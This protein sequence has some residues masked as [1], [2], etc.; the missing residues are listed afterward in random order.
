MGTHVDYG[1]SGPSREEKYTR[2]VTMGLRN[3]KLVR[4]IARRGFTPDDI[5]RQTLS[6]RLTEGG[7]QCP[8]TNR[9]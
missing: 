1:G 9:R 3:G 6:E 8:T 2:Y 7:H 4:I 5:I